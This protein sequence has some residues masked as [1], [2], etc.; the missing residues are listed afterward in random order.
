MCV[1]MTAGALADLL[2]AAAMCWSLYH[3][4]TGFARQAHPADTYVVLTFMHRTD[5]MI[6]TLMTYSI[7][8][9]LLTM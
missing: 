4:R 9:G 3:R 6:I 8:S 2:I 5:S 7:S 1:G